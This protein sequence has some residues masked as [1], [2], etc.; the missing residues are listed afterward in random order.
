MGERNAFALV[1]NWLN[2]TTSG[3]VNSLQAELA[4]RLSL[5]ISEVDRNGVITF[6]VTPI[7]S[8]LI[9]ERYSVKRYGAVGDGVTDDTVAIQDAVT[10]ALAMPGGGVVYFPPGVYAHGTSLNLVGTNIQIIGANAT[11]Y[12]TGTGVA[13]SMNGGA[14]AYYGGG[15]EGL[16]IKGQ[17]NC[18]KGLVLDNTHHGRFLNVVVQDVNG[19]AFE[20]TNSVC[21]YFENLRCSGNEQGT[22]GTRPVTGLKLIGWNCTAN[23]FVNT[24]MEGMSGDGILFDGAT[25]N[26][27][28][29]G[30]SEGC[31]RG[32]TLPADSDYNYFQNIDCEA[33]TVSD[34]DVAS[35]FNIFSGCLGAS[36]VALGGIRVTAGVTN[37]V[38]NGMYHNIIVGAAALNTSLLYTTYSLYAAPDLGAYT[39]AGTHTCVTGMVNNQTAAVTDTL[40]LNGSAW[41]LGDETL[42]GLLSIARPAATDTAFYTSKTDATADIN[43][44]FS[45]TV[46]GGMSWGPGTAAVDV[47]LYR[48]APNVLATDYGLTVGAALTVGGA[49]NHDGATAGFY[50]TAPIAQAVLA[51]GTVKTVDDVITALQN[52][53]LVKQS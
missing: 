35:S 43:P 26:I 19:I 17:A 25:R 2:N 32:I 31:A 6:D 39:N 45:M 28:L 16:I 7:I 48:L 8:G 30:T 49:L 23:T 29:G 20:F 24:I 44:R 3:E 33:N 11:L 42:N 40:Q 38:L 1:Q 13:V 51:T 12:F 46:N 4:R 9:S 47:N 52:L 22:W 10:A 41:I 5:A 53:G 27:F 21:N 15:I 37:L 50:G 34:I 14:T 36:K 18:T